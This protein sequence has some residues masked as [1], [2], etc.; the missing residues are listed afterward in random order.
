MEKSVENGRILNRCG[1]S[2]MAELQ[3][4]KLA[5]RVRF[6]SPA[7]MKCEIC[8]RKCKINREKQV[9]FCGAKTLKIA[10]V[11]LHEW[12]EPIISGERGSGA[13][14]FSHCSLKC[15]YCQNCE[16]SSFG[17]GKELSVEQLAEIFK[18]LEKAGANNINLVS[19]THYLNEIISAFKIYKPKIPIVWNTS[20]FETVETIKKLKNYVDIFL[21]DLKY[22][23]PE[24]SK[25]FS[26]AENY[27]EFA[28]K[29][30]LQMRK[31]QPKDI[32]ENG[33]MKKGLIVRH[34][35][36]PSCHYDSIKIFN[37]INKNLENETI[38]SLMSQ[39]IPCHE[40]LNNKKL[41]RKLKP[42]EYK[43]V[44]SHVEKL[45]FKNGYFQDFSSAQSCY[46]PDFKA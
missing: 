10:K 32:I 39:Y 23:S 14:F 22:F 42:L 20:G 33:I 36:L 17:E 46:I 29:A 7:P 3:L 24:L 40:A 13:I 34:L 28:S 25:D 18:D 4:P 11:M 21:T 6:P 37:W 1:R 38:V 9:G 30:I 5:T 27:F 44:L 2:S 8:P 41:N 16:I 26:K 31:N 43:I 12:E 45:G 19:P 35:V 15:L